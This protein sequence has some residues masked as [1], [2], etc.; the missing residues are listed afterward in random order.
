MQHCIYAT[1]LTSGIYYWKLHFLDFKGYWQ[2]RQ[3]SVKLSNAWNMS[4]LLLWCFN[5]VC[6]DFDALSMAI[7]T[8]WWPVTFSDVIIMSKRLNILGINSHMNLYMS[9]MYSF[10]IY[11]Q[12]E[13]FGKNKALN[14]SIKIL[15]KFFDLKY[16]LPD[17]PFKHETNWN[18][19]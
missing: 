12:N 9:E 2:P 15:L 11:S 4:I 3:K 14:S 10:T 16:C 6:S 5:K 13:Q 7:L 8:F 17:M 1:H 18:R 19:F